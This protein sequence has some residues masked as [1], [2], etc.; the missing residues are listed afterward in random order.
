MQIRVF[1]QI[2][3]VA[4]RFK[5][6]GV[7][8]DIDPLDLPDSVWTEA[9]NMVAQP[10]RMKRALGHREVWASPLYPPTWLL[11]TPQVTNRYWMIGHPQN[12]TVV[13]DLGQHSDITPASLTQVV[14]ANGWSGGNLN[15]LAV[16]NSLENAPVYWYEGQPT[17][18]DLPGMRTDT[19]YKIMRPFKYHL[20]GLGVNA[21]GGTY[22]DQVHW[23]NAAD[24]GQIPDTWVPAP[25]NEAGDNILADETGEIVDGM[26][27]RDSFYIYKHDSVYEMTYIGGNSVFRFRKVFGTTGVLSRNCIAR[28]EGTHVVLGNGDIYRH[29]GQNIQSIVDGKL[30]E[31][32]FASIDDDNFDRSFVVYL[33]KSSEVWFCVPTAGQ[34]VPNVAL[35]WNVTTGEFG[36]RTLPEADYAAAGIIANVTGTG[37]EIWDSDA[38]EWDQD[39]TG[40]LDQTVDATED[41]ILIADQQGDKLFQADYGTTHDG[42]DYTAIVGKMG[43]MLD[44]PN[45]KAIRRIWPRINAPEETLFNIE[46]FGQREGSQGGPAFLGSYEYKIGD[47]DGLAVNINARWFGLRCLCDA[48]VEWDISGYDVAYLPRGRH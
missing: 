27:L 19:R 30:R 45:M 13:N 11:Y 1:Y 35:T 14:P 22:M 47:R 2:D 39:T 28:V 46:V 20:I 6:L 10:G 21:P 37:Q 44:D 32:F 9:A 48:A 17:A 26:T 23:S 7:N 5:L 15:G 42:A 34:T 3:C 43:M 41:S 24:P 38:G 18:I 16:A 29:D 4:K 12:L 33:E 31:A 36:Y 25:D 8:L 40:W